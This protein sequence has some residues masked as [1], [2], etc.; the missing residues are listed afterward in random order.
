[1][2]FCGLGGE[3]QCNAIKLLCLLKRVH[4]SVFS[5]Q[6]VAT[7]VFCSCIQDQGEG[8]PYSGNR[9]LTPAADGI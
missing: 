7:R 1:M 8:C 6:K 5:G 9:G 4:Y 3:A 2:L